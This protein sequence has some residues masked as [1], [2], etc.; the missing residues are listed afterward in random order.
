M[1]SARHCMGAAGVV[2]VWLL[3]VKQDFVKVLQPIGNY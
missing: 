1:Q 3:S 2:N